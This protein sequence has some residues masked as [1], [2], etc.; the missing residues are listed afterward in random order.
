VTVAIDRFTGKI[1]G[2]TDTRKWSLAAQVV[3]SPMNMAVHAGTWGGIITRLLE[4]LMG[5]GTV[6]MAWTGV[7]QWW[8]KRVKRVAQRRNSRLKNQALKA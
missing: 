4:F 2:Q 3:D 1:L 8:L 5:L 7:R 6:Y